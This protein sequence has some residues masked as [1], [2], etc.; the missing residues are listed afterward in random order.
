M[1]RVSVT[2]QAVPLA[3]LAPVLTA[4]TVANDVC[5]VGRVALMVTNGSGSSITVTVVMPA[6][7]DGDITV[8]PRTVTVAAS[9]TKLIPLTSVNYK[10]T[11]ASVDAGQTADIGRAYVNYSAVASVTRGVVALP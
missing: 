11:A 1:A 5:D 3:G 9:A 8:G 6:L 10:Q 4:P 2:T 7:V